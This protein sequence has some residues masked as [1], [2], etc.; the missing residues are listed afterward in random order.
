M[1]ACRSR[2][3]SVRL[4]LLPYPLHEYEAMFWLLDEVSQYQA[5]VKDTEDKLAIAFQLRMYAELF[6]HYASCDFKTV[7]ETLHSIR[8]ENVAF[9]RLHALANA[10]IET[11]AESMAQLGVHLKNAEADAAAVRMTKKHRERLEDGFVVYMAQMAKLR[12][13]LLRSDSLNEG[14]VPACFQ[15]W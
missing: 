3:A 8:L 12:S 4:W 7:T 5:Q 1:V 9:S 13:N 14:T 11:R 2:R 15:A 6:C 10:V